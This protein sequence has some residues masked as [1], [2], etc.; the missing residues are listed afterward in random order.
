MEGARDTGVNV[1]ALLKVDVLEEIAAHA[2]CGN[3]ITVYVGSGKMRDRALY[4][5]QSLA[6]ILVN[7]WL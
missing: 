6:E 2:S 4:R 3:G 7:P 5:H 1:I